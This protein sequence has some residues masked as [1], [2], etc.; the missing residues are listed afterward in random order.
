MLVL[1]RFFSLHVGLIV[2]NSVAASMFVCIYVSIARYM[3]A[4]DF[5]AWT[6]V[7]EC[8]LWRHVHTHTVHAYDI[9]ACR[10]TL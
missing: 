7:C 10:Y 2:R 1:Y 5:V 4:Y 3:Y 6:D 9:Y 8:A